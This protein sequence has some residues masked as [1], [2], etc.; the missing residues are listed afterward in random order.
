[1]SGIPSQITGY[2]RDNRKH[3][4]SNP[5]VT[6]ISHLGTFFDLAA[7]EQMQNWLLDK[8]HSPL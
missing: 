5:H 7:D 4:P 2:D 6:S 8:M 3:M 1:M